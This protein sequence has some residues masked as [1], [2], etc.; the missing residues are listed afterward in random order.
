MRKNIA[1]FLIISAV[2]AFA[3]STAYA[4]SSHCNLT[5]VVFKNDK[6][7][8]K[9]VLVEPLGAF[10]ASERDGIRALL[11][12][13]EEWFIKNI[14]GYPP[15]PEAL[16][17]VGTGTAR[18]LTAGFSRAIRINPGF[19]FPLYL[20]TPSG[21][22]KTG[23]R[24]IP[25]GRVSL[26]T[27]DIA[28]PPLFALAA[29]ETVT[30]LE[31]LETASEEP[32]FGMDVGLF[33]DNKTP[34]GA[35]Y[36]FG[37]QPFGNPGL[38]FGTQAP[39]HM[40]FFH[41]NFIIKLAAP[42][43]KISHV[44]YRIRLYTSLASLAFKTGH[45]YWGYRFAGW[46]LHYIQ[47]MAVPYHARMT[48]GIGTLRLIW[49]NLFY[50]GEKRSGLLN[51]LSNRHL[52]FE[53]YQYYA[54]IDLMGKKA[55]DSPLLSTLADTSPDA[56]AVPYSDRYVRDVVS[57]ASYAVADDIDDLMGESFPIKYVSDPAFLFGV[58]EPE[59]DVYGF[60]KRENPTAAEKMDRAMVPILQRLGTASRLYMK[61][62]AN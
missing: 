55:Y 42:F 27:A 48:P 18:D 30:A 41:E 24:V 31:V 25:V 60:L 38:D 4:W 54:L 62:L 10:L 50:S 14:P 57:I 8:E 7:L 22:A 59:I 11:K 28:N 20:Q 32:D 58:T 35:E 51:I 46:A 13:E 45:D 26:V 49:A 29:G 56:K 47:D 40:A 17:F 21:S 16:R 19:S 39:F 15:V 3:A 61:S 1:I 53:K 36:G 12:S 23:K 2:Y 52:V 33:T 43:S 34:F 37:T 9:Q 44:E 6:S 5:R